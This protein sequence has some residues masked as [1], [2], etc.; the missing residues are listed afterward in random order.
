MPQVYHVRS[1]N[2]EVILPLYFTTPRVKY[3][4]TFCDHLVENAQYN[5]HFSFFTEAAPRATGNP[6]QHTTSVPR[7]R[8]A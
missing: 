5:A 3:R 6:D 4:P 7:S 8:H 2:F 1:K